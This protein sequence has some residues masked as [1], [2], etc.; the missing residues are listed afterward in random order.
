MNINLKLEKSIYV[1]AI[2]RGLTLAIPFLLLGSFALLLNSFP[3]DAYQQALELCLNGKLSQILSTIF[4]VSLGSLALILI[5][6]ISI[7]FGQM[8]GNDDVLL[9]GASSLCAYGAFCGGFQPDTYVFGADWVFSAMCITLISCGLLRKWL[10]W[11]YKVQRFHTVGADYIFNLAMKSILPIT[12][13]LVL[14]AV[15]GMCLRTMTGQNNITNF[16]SYLSLLFFGRVGATLLGALIYVIFTQMLWFFGIHGTN[17]LDEVVKNLFEKGIETNQTLI[18]SGQVATEIFSKTFLD[19]FVFMGGCGTAICLIFALLI[20]AK[21]S[22]NRKLALVSSPFVLFNISEIVIFG[23]PVIFNP[24]MLVPFILTPVVL[25]FISAIM[26]HFHIVPMAVQTVGWTVPLF[27]SGYQA[28]G[29]LLGSVLQLVN[30]IV[31]TC[32]YIPFVRLSEKQQTEV[33][34]DHVKSMEEVMTKGEETGN[35]PK[36]MDNQCPLS[37]A[38]KTLSVDLRNAMGRE[39][40]DLYYQVQMCSDGTVF[41]AEALMRW[42]HPVAGFIAPPL[43]IALAYEGRFLPELGYYLV[44]RACRDMKLMKSRTGKPTHISVNVSP[45]QLQ[46]DDFVERV[47]AIKKAYGIDEKHLVLEITERVLLD[48]SQVIIDKISRLRQGGIEIS[49]DDFGMGHG[50]MVYLQNNAFEEVKLDGNLVKQLLT[51]ERSKSIVSGIINLT[52]GLQCRV[53]SEFVETETQRELLKKMGCH[54][55]QGFL[56]DRAQPLEQFIEKHL[57]NDTERKKRVQL[58]E[59]KNQNER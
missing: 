11:S 51:N 45:H 50:S 30:V 49:L 9:Y 12:M 15:V 36:F 44:D 27:M 28:T 26:M 46:E 22:N 2:R 37:Y 41:G 5:I 1:L 14:F 38:A 55:Y 23:F 19:T 4:D 3:W 13:M 58:N 29:S 10:R 7:S 56:Y 40:V 53:V 20:I 35:F 39:Q 48:T 32:I 18:Q 59:E 42:K 33:F 6:T 8:E 54:I 21:K 57:C 17:T 25:L 24:L 52:R 43:L 34:K 47:L 16:G 31:G